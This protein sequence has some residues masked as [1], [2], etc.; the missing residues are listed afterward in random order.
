MNVFCRRFCICIYL[1]PHLVPGSRGLPQARKT[2]ATF[3]RLTMSPTTGGRCWQT[4]GMST[5]LIALQ[6]PSEG[7]VFGPGFWTYCKHCSTRLPKSPLQTWSES[8]LL[9]ENKIPAPMKKARVMKLILKTAIS[10]S[11]F[12]YEPVV[13][14]WVRWLFI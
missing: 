11:G 13:L 1:L 8:T 3:S 5:V 14:V 10:L 7:G 9:R 2:K 6:H 4:H 12:F